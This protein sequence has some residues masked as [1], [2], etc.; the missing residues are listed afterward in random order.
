MTDVI[1]IIDQVSSTEVIVKCAHC[2][3][4]GYVG[5]SSYN[6]DGCPICK[7][8]GKLLI[9]A[10]RLPLVACARCEGDGV[11]VYDQSVCTSCHGAGCQ[12]IAGKWRI[13]P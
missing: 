2:N 9:E 5:Y 3:G 13:V 4:R 12:A 7:G 11:I 1:V 6:E 10:E 8:K